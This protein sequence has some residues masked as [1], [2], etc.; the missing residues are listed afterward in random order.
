MG[1][2]PAVS[3]SVEEAEEPPAP[4]EPD[5]SLFSLVPTV[6]EQIESIAEAQAEENEQTTKRS[7]PARRGARRTAP[8]TPDAPEGELTAA[9]HTH[10]R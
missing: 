1:E 8:K 4:A 5:L 7:R 6:E 3:A 9:V 10:T 2:Q